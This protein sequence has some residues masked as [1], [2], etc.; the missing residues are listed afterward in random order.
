MQ[1]LLKLLD[2]NIYVSRYRIWG[3]EVTVRDILWTHPDSIKLLN[4]FPI[5]LI[6]DST[7]KTNMYKLPLLDM[8][9]V[10][11]T[12]KTYSVMFAFLETVKEENVT[13]AL[14]VSQSMLKDQEEMPKVI[15]TDHDTALMNSVAKVFHTSYALLY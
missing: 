3:D 15:V 9:G 7:Y 1:Q 4:A 5:M 2:D 11:S 8:V 6:I 13:R 14:E 10:T 12:E